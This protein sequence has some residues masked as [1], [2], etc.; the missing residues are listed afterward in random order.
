MLADSNGSEANLPFELTEEEQEIV[1][2]RRS[3]FILG[4]SG[5]GKTT[6]LTMK[7]FGNEE[8]HDRASK[9]SGTNID[10]P[11]TTNFE[12]IV[13]DA[14]HYVLRQLFVTVSPKL[15]FAVKLH[16]SQLKRCVQCHKTLFEPMA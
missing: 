3:A 6:V 14:R 15:C 16:A 8:L 13:E 4:R 10:A 12:E 7:L 9:G 11:P 5:T 1:L 2:F